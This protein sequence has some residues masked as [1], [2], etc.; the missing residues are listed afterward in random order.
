MKALS[1]NIRE[2]HPNMMYNLMTAIAK[3]EGGAMKSRFTLIALLFVSFCASGSEGTTGDNSAAPSTNLP[4]GGKP[5][6]WT[7]A[8]ADEFSVNGLPDKSKWDYDTSHNKN[9]WYNHELQYYSRDRLE[10]AKV[11]NGH[12]IITARKEKMRSARDYGGQA[13]T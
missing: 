4:S 3:N 2:T 5:A 6:G 13:Y 12:L 9:G 8:W 11:E 1:F 7:L 10:N